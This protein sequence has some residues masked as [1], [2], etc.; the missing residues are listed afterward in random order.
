MTERALA[1]FR[2]KLESRAVEADA[3]HATAPLAD[4]LRW[5]LGELG[6]LNGNGHSSSH[7]PGSPE[8]LLTAREVAERLK[9]SRRYVY[10]QA[11]TFPFTVRLAPHAVRFSASG[12]DRWLARTR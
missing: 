7:A 12:L 1:E 5:V 4:V 9:C 11:A 6:S 10:A 2:A 3:T 8:T